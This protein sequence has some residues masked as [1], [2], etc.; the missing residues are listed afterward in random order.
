[1]EVEAGQAYSSY[2]ITHGVGLHSNRDNQRSLNLALISAAGQPWCH[3]ERS[4]SLRAP[5]RPRRL[6]VNHKTTMEVSYGNNNTRRGN[7]REFNINDG[8]LSSRS[9]S[10]S[11]ARVF[12][13]TRAYF[14]CAASRANTTAG[15]ATTGSSE[16]AVRRIKT[17]S[18][19]RGGRS[20]EN[21]GF[22]A[23]KHHQRPC[24]R[25]CSGCLRSGVRV[26]GR[27]AA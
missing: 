3:E 25:L 23:F 22:D 10:D 14:Y 13:S 5:F 20:R 12:Y 9:D 18:A 6:Y 17:R 19:S 21:L 27:G 2:D 4:L 16:R 24:R 11:G 1:M 15:S 8:C 26:G 7:S